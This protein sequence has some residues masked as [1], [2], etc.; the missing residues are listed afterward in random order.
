MESLIHSKHLINDGC[1]GNNNLKNWT[2]NVLAMVDRTWKWKA[3]KLPLKNQRKLTGN[4]EWRIEEQV[5]IFQVP[6]KA[7]SFR[8]RETTHERGRFEGLLLVSR[9]VWL[10][11]KWDK[12][13]DGPEEMVWSQTAKGLGRRLSVPTSQ[14]L[15]V[16]DYDVCHGKALTGRGGPVTLEEG[17]SKESGVWKYLLF[18]C[19]LFGLL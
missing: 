9:C 16:A 6:E 18:L 3:A 11:L 4:C 12:R 8:K 1:D 2:N 19:A 14:G 17:A 13:W 5:E 15:G 7:E 10:Q